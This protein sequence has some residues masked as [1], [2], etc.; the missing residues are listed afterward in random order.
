MGEKHLGETFDIHG[1]GID[2]QF[3]HHENEI[4]QS[5]GAHH[6]HPLANYWMHNG[7]LQVEGEKMSKSLGNFITIHE[8]LVDWPGQVLRFNMLRTHYRQPIDWTLSAL[9]ESSNIYFE[10]SDTADQ[11]V[12]SSQ[13]AT[14]VLEALYNDL[15]TPLA[16]AELQKLRA[17]ATKG[18][19]TAG[20]ELAAS[21]ELMG[22]R[23]ERE[24]VTVVPQLSQGASHATVF[25]E[26]LD[27][28]PKNYPIGRA[29]TVLAKP[30]MA[31][32]QKEVAVI[33]D[34]LASADRQVLVGHA[35]QLVEKLPHIN[36]LIQ[37]RL[38]ARKA[39]KFAEADTI[40]AQ[41]TEIGIAIEDGPT[42]TTWK[43]VS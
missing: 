15:N 22:L 24:Y 26:F 32:F 18:N 16:I 13:P 11:F 31:D 10:L 4:A 8:L 7:F 27:L 20:A 30:N 12:P 5:E 38:D 25:T 2:L 34:L 43:V 33:A 41:L 3:P 28:F 35:Q 42:G 17:A 37:L 21:L 23:R 19:L 9:T 40:R 14:S 36:E 1:G 29:L 39:K 6:G